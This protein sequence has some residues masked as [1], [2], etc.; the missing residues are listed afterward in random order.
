MSGTAPAVIMEFILIQDMSLWLHY[1]VKA[2]DKVAE[3]L[4][5]QDIQKTLEGVYNTWLNNGAD[6]K[7]KM[8]SFSL[9]FCF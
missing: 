2:A 6:T 9:C 3:I 5:V 8:I 1:C 7:L 4:N